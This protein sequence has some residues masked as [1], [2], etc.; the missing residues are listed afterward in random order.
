MVSV[1]VGVSRLRGRSDLGLDFLAVSDG[2][3]DV[4]DVAALGTGLLID[5]RVVEV[6][7]NV[8]EGLR[9]L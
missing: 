2:L 1:C 7:L 8:V 4:R 3:P 5:E 9:S 6:A